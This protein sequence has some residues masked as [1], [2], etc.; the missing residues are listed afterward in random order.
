MFLFMSS[1]S[2]HTRLCTQDPE[3]LLGTLLDGTHVVHTP[4]WWKL[5]YDGTTNTKCKL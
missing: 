2:V 4:I 5:Q 3:S 1:S